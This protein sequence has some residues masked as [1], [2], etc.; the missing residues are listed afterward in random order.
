MISSLRTRLLLGTIGGMVLLLACFSLI[1]YAVIRQALLGEFDRSLASTA[2]IMAASIEIDA[3]DI[4]VE[5][6]IRQTPEFDDAGRSALYQIWKPDGEIV[7]KSPLLG[8]R[9]LPRFHGP[10][11][12]PVHQA[13]WDPCDHRPH[14][15]IGVRF[16]PRSEAENPGEPGALPAQHALVLVVARDTGA[17][18]S[19]LDF[20]KWLLLAAA[21]VTTGLTLLVGNIA[22]HRGLHPL[23][24]I[25]AEIAA[26][27]EKSL[28]IR[29]G[30]ES[31]PVEIEPIRDRLNSLLSRLRDAFERERRFSANVAHE[32]R[33]PLAGIRSTIEVTLARSR[34]NGEYRQALSECLE[35]TDGLQAMVGNLLMLA[36]M[37]ADQMAF[38]MERTLLSELVDASWKPF[39][40]RAAERR[41]TFE[42]RVSND[43]SLM[44]DRRSLSIV[45][46]NLFSNAVAYADHGG[47]VWTQAEEADGLVEIVVANTGCRLSPDQT[48]RVFDRFWRADASRSEAGTHCGLGLSLVR[49]IVQALG[50]STHVTVKDA[51][52]ILR[53]AL[54]CHGR[55]G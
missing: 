36:R 4:E 23:Q 43:L 2:E 8:G 5:F 47:R 53:L 14:R 52:F 27:N 18:L 21:G 26:I 16:S 28:D 9:D 48:S 12:A 45:F 55:G 29:I 3:N 1:V 32:L 33:N 44:C 10:G 51:T 7:A 46:S 17:L 22:V 39:S 20:L 31:T 11:G 30:N 41:I 42:N 49:R 54:P 15:A 50:G 24:S 37:D 40:S 13:F 38:D 19:Q 35:I 25:A 34:D 6:E